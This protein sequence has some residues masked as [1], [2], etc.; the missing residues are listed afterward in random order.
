MSTGEARGR[1]IDAHF[2]QRGR[3]LNLDLKL[4]LNE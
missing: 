4:D 1:G 3:T 2:I